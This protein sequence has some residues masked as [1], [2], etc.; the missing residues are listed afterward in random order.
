MRP[1]VITITRPFARVAVQVEQ[2]W[3]IVFLQCRWASDDD[4]DQDDDADYY[5]AD[6]NDDVDYDDDAD[7]D[8][9]DDADYGEYEGN[10]TENE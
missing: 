5:D 7:Y 2:K 10:I 9:D 8:D 3:R 1:T 6:D 4:V